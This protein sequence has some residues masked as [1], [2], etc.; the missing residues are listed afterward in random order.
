MIRGKTSKFE[1]L[2]IIDH[3]YFKFN[4]DQ[5]Y[6]HAAFL[7]TKKQLLT[8]VPPNSAYGFLFLFCDLF[9]YYWK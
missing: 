6:E 3:Y 5:K 7:S 9:L 1:L 2:L 4:S 8:D